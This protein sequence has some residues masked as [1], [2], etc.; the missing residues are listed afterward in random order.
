M[1]N[2]EDFEAALKEKHGKLA[3]VDILDGRGSAYFTAPTEEAFDVF[4]SQRDTPEE[5][6]AFRLY[7][8]S[9]F[10]VSVEYDESG[11]VKRALTW[12]E[13]SREEGPAWAIAVA[14]H[15]VNMLSGSLEGGAQKARRL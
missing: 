1:S 4:A 14:G 8:Q 15:A 13:V 7:V 6:R 10:V 9:A 3:A 12:V 11:E 5:T 2:R